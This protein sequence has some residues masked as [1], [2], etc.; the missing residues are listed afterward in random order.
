[1]AACAP[2]FDEVFALIRVGGEGR[3]RRDCRAHEQPQRIRSDWFHTQ[4][5]FPA[6][7]ICR[8]RLPDF[9]TGNRLLSPASDQRGPTSQK[10]PEFRRI[11]AWLTGSPQ[12]CWQRPTSTVHWRIS[13][14]RPFSPST[15][16]MKWT[17]KRDIKFSS[18]LEQEAGPST[19]Q[20]DE[21]AS[22]C[23]MTYCRV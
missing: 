13:C 1:M 2:S 9:T 5:T 11:S 3:S 23:D 14:S 15:S 6:M 17:T 16:F 21:C 22:L 8:Q 7:D 12:F 18:L 10:V 19:Q 4:I 20:S